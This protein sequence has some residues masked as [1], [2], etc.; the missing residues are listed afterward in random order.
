MDTFEEEQDEFAVREDMHPCC[1]H[2]NHGPLIFG[3]LA[4]C[5]A[6]ETAGAPL[7][8]VVA[9]IEVSV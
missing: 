7:F 5:A 9:E 1:E 4:A 8:E 6:C 2:C 3:H